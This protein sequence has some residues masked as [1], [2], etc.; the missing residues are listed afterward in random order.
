[1]LFTACAPPPHVSNSNSPDTSPASQVSSEPTLTPGQESSPTPTTTTQVPLLM[2]TSAVFHGGEVGVGYA[3]VSL[4]ATGGV[5]P[6]SWSISLGSLPGDVTATSSGTVSGTPT[7]A[8][9]A[10]FTV[11]VD[12]SAGHSAT[13]NRSITVAAPL[14]VTGVCTTAAPCAVEDGCVTVCGKFANQSGG[15]GPF[16]YARV[17]TL[18]AGMGLSG[19]SLTGP[20]PLPPVGLTLPPPYR[21][22]VTVK[23]SLGATGSVLAQF[24]VF[25]HIKLPDYNNPNPYAA[26]VA[27]TIALPYTPGSPQG[28]PTA[29]LMKGALPAGSTYYVDSAKHYLVIQVPPQPISRLATP[30]S[31]TFQL[32]DSAQCGPATGQLCAAAGTATFSIF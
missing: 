21:F 19:L 1:M 23:D 30:Y 31:P 11:R 9:N 5:M 14:A 12:D 16:T 17:G 2:I 4:H 22:Q 26:G 3:P 10:P 24:S 15:V 28:S 27:V 6:Y 8:G 7:A 32:T 18:P 13:V 20:F 29:K 25:G